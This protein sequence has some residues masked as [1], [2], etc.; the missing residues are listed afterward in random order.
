MIVQYDESILSYVASIREYFGLSSSF[1]P[2]REL[3]KR[4][5]EEK[6]KRIYLILIDAMGANLLKRKLSSEAFLNRNMLASTTTVF[7]PTTTAATTAIRNGKAPNENGWIGWSQYLREVDDIVIPFLS[8]SY[9]SDTEYEGDIFQKYVPVTATD[10]ELQKM[11]IPAR[12]LNPAFDPDGCESV[13][14]MCERLK[15]YSFEAD[16]RYIYAY[17]DKYDSMMHRYGPSSKVCD[18]YLADI[19]ALLEELSEEVAEGTML[20]ITADHGQIDVHRSYDLYGSRFQKYFTRRPSVE[21]R[22]MSFCIKEDLRE[23]FEREFKKEFENDYLLLSYEQ[24]KQL[25]IFGTNEDH[26]RM[27]EFVGDY[28]AI[29]KSDMSFRY[30][31]YNLVEF[32]GEHAGMC[33]DEL[34]IP[35]IVYMKK[36]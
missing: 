33:D 23:E 27:K 16:Y 29:A 24:V 1:A 20:V 14:E 13:N 19:N 3:S 17:W 18:L 2:N 21:P 5:A 25:K 28:L 31:E 4:I 32:K 15:K 22:A 11:G 6:P 12:T 9:Y 8:A 35:V 7:P 10:E 36:K 26:P 30:S 34:Q